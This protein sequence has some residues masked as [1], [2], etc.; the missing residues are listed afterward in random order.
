M[1]SYLIGG[2]GLVALLA[3]GFATVQTKRLETKQREMALVQGQLQTCGGRLAAILRDV[4]SDN[5]VDN[6]DLTDFDIP[7]DWM[8]PTDPPNP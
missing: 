7:A 6:L 4:E 5:E 3:G 2:L 1:I 8:R